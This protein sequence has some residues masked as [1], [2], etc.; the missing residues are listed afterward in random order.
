MVTELL[1]K[2]LNGLGAIRS[3]PL[4]HRHPVRGATTPKPNKSLPYFRKLPS[5]P[6]ES[7][8]SRTFRNNAKRAEA[9]RQ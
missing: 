5:C 3:E 2:P 7:R 6:I 4:P 1:D 9:I 8:I